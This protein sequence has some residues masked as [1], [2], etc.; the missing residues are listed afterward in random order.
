MKKRKRKKRKT[1]LLVASRFLTENLTG[2]TSFFESGGKF[3]II[4]SIPTS[5]TC[6]KTKPSFFIEFA[7]SL[8]VTKYLPYS[9]TLG[10]HEKKRHSTHKSFHNLPT[11]ILIRE[12]HGGMV[13]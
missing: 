7:S 13:I 4:V 9:I 3:I 11:S 1:T 6:L 5:I 10:L 12:T 8:T 2:I